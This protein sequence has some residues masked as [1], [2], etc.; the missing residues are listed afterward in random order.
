MSL[1]G[2][3]LITCFLARLII[4]YFLAYLSFLP[5]IHMFR[6][7]RRKN[8]SDS[9]PPEARLWWLLYGETNPNRKD[10]ISV[11]SNNHI[12][13]SHTLPPNW[14]LRLRL[15]NPRTP[16]CPLDR[17]DDLHSGNRNRQ[18]RHFSQSSS[19]H[20]PHISSSILIL[21]SIQST[22]LQ[23]TTQSLHTENTQHQLP[24][25]MTSHATF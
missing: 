25:A 24:E 7:R 8:G 18:R 12:M 4:G 14:P 19:M 17:T 23:S 15:D 1:R 20:T 10:N 5:S 21:P 11:C 9:V 22:N 16:K 6:Q 13:P 3:M 2:C